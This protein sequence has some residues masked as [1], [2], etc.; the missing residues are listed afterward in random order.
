LRSVRLDN[1]KEGR[2]EAKSQ[3]AGP[4]RAPPFARGVCGEA[5]QDK[6]LRLLSPRQALPD[7]GKGEA[8][9]RRRIAVSGGLDLV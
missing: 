4:V 5:P 9:R 6:R 2:V 7:H 3:E 1:E 8:E